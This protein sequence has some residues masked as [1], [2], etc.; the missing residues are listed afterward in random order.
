[1]T[2]RYSRQ[3]RFAG[4]G[5]AG[6]GR[7]ESFKVAVAGCGALGSVSSEM[8]V[9]GGF[10][11]VR[12]IDR[13]Y[14]EENNLQRQSLFSEDD[15]EKGLPKAIAA[16]TRLRQINSNVKIEGVVEDLNSS[17]IDDL[18]RGFDLI[19]DGTDNF[20]TRFL[21]N[22][23]SV[24]NGV[25][26]IYGA[27]LGSYG[28]AFPVLPGQGPCLQCVFEQAP[29][30]GS[31]DTCETA[32]VLAPVVHMISSFQ[33]THALK[34]AVQDEPEKS[35]GIFQ[36]DIW[37][38]TWRTLDLPK[39]RDDCA[40]CVLGRFDYLENRATSLESRLCGRG[41]IQI[42]PGRD[43]E[44]DWTRIRKRLSEYTSGPSNQYVLRF[45]A[46][47][48]DLALFRDGRAIIKG[49]SDPARA[50]SIYSRYIGN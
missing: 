15:V 35:T 25:P 20:E 47:D 4:I 42:R 9:R 44:I 24:R 37:Q 21:L 3:A 33:V 26:W 2:E 40:C 30:V 34:L 41:A 32:G 6:Q 27:V 12:V 31:M 36:V 11:H 19:I 1:M 46:D 45:T 14:L 18:C 49:T 38:D 10:G 28:I 43:S 29:P 50:R 22:D 5:S 8:L 13:D 23:W 48:L 39:R 17:T 7:I 16:R